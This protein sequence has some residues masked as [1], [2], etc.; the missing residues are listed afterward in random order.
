MI[1]L[2]ACP[3]CHQP[4]ANITKVSHYRSTA[5]DAVIETDLCECPC[6]HAFNTPQP[7]LEE[8]DPFYNAGDYEVFDLEP[9]PDPVTTAER[10]KSATDRYNHI[11][12][13]KGGNFLDIGCGLG[14]V[15]MAMSQLGMHA[16][17]V[18]PS[19]V[20]AKKCQSIGLDVFCGTLEEAKL[21]DAN[22]DSMSMFHVLEH[23]PDPVATLTECRRILKPGG[24]LFIG[25]PNFDSLLRS[26]VGSI[27]RPIQAPVHL[28]HFRQ[29]S[30]ETSARIAGLRVV[31][32]STES[33]PD[34]VEHELAHWL[35]VRA[36]VPKKLS[37][38][39][40]RPFARYLA[41]TGNRSGRGEAIIATLKRAA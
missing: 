28:H 4:T 20:A 1:H 31:Q 29:K 21:P 37:V 9:M 30:L 8:L 41:K 6:G 27:W 14:S 18:E 33:I 7:T 22:F 13:V 17:G 12:V 10:I 2:R 3:A 16:Q 38:P 39:V 26:L 23:V 11:K 40:L 32:S 19:P 15:V 35:R 25:V 34:H 24:E 36:L 5:K